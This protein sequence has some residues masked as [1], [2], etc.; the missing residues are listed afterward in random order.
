MGTAPAQNFE[1]ND[2]KALTTLPRTVGVTVS[3]KF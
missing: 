2:S 1:G 3:Y